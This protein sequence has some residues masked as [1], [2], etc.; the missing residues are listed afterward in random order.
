M[1]I[2]DLKPVQ[3]EFTTPNYPEWIPAKKVEHK[4]FDCK[5][6]GADLIRGKDE[7]L[8]VKCYKRWLER[9]KINK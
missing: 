2:K 7:Y 9:R 6:D 3:E 8:C 5:E 4:C 1:N